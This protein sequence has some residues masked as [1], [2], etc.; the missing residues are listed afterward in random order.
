MKPC[1]REAGNVTGLIGTIEYRLAGEARPA[2]NTT[3]E[4]LDV[5]RFA[6]EL[7]QRGGTHLI[8]E[9]SSHALA[10]GRVLWIP[11]PHG[12]FHQPHARSSGFSRNHGRVRSG[13]AAAV[14][15]EGRPAPEWAVLNRDDAWTGATVPLGSRVLFYGMSPEAELRAENVRSGFDGLRFDLCYQSVRQPVESAMVGRIN[16]LN[17]LAAA[18]AGLSYG[19]DLPAHRPWDRG[20]PSCSRPV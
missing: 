3:P 10:L 17:I 12:R 7:E 8:S 20:V 9:V 14:C 6:A 16:V 1:L 18:G 4:S 11:F 13:E 5:M 15:A 2:P 19:M